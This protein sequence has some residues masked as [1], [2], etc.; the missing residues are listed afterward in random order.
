MSN[1]CSFS[2]YEE[3]YGSKES[4]LHLLHLLAFDKISLVQSY[5][6]GYRLC[7]NRLSCN[8]HILTPPPPPPLVETALNVATLK[9]KSINNKW[10]EVNFIG[11]MNFRLYTLKHAQ[12][13]V[14][15]ITAHGSYW[16]IRIPPQWLLW[17]RL[18]LWLLSPDILGLHEHIITPQTCFLLFSTHMTVWHISSCK[19]QCLISCA[20]LLLIHVHQIKVV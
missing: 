12:F 9:N 1:L 17:K 18:Q 15:S 14:L 19:I 10:E 6:A 13:N 7:I 20:W 5:E 2:L 16:K 11:H 3:I 8:S 4:M